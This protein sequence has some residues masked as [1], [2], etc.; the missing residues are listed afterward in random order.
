MVHSYFS[1][2]FGP[3]FKKPIL[4]LRIGSKLRIAGMPAEHL[5]S[6]EPCIKRKPMFGW[7][8]CDSELE[9]N[10][11]AQDWF[12]FNMGLSIWHLLTQN[13]RYIIR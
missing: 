10:P 11:Q 3:I 13:H 1:I 6:L 7:H 2:I 4:G 9:F 12:F 8:P 5:F